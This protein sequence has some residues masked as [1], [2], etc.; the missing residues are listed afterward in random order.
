MSKTIGNVID[1]YKVIEKYGVEPTRYY[2]L[3]QIPTLDDGDF[4]IQHFEE[5]YQADLANGLGNLVAR[6]AGMANTSRITFKKGKKKKI[7][8]KVSEA[9]EKFKLNIALD[10]VW[11]QIKKADVL[12][13]EKRVWELKGDRKKKILTKLVEQIRQ[14]A[15]DLYPF[16]PET[17]R[18]IERQFKGPEIEFQKPLFPRLR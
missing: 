5:V 13:N 6:V 12:I 4:T 17:A 11:N 1:P 10:L 14:I 3:S 15:T 9:I 18:E 2:L 8:K 7:S 16:L